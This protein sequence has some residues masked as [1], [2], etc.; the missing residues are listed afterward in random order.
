MKNRK[1]WDLQL[2]L[3]FYNFAMVGLSTYIA[4]EV[5]TILQFR[6]TMS[7]Y[8]NVDFVQTLGV[9]WCSRSGILLAMSAYD[10][11]Y[12]SGTYEGSYMT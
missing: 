2:V 10:I 1:Q 8:L 11:L 12:T 5:I 3:F 9:L 4:T 7:V 6:N